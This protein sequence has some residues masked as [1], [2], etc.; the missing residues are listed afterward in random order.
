[1]S[2]NIHMLTADSTYDRC[3]KLLEDRLTDKRLEKLNAIVFLSLKKKGRGQAFERLSNEKFK[4]LIDIAFEKGI[5]IGFDSCSAPKFLDSVKDRVDYE[6]LKMCAE[7]CE[8]TLFSLYISTEGIAYPC[9]FLEEE[10][11]KGV[12]MLKVKDFMGEVWNSKELS[13][14]REDVLSTEK[15]Q[16]CR[17]C[18]CYEI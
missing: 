12:D 15:G 3:L 16:I 2:V 4:T 18:P 10:K 1:M 11:Y 5:S 14:F 13:R 6:R 17:S 9:S 8:S 7:P